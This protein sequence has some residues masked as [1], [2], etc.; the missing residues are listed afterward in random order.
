MIDMLC[1][2]I[3]TLWH[4]IQIGFLLSL[5]ATLVFLVLYFLYRA[6]VEMANDKAKEK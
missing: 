1:K 2:A 5:A 3:E 6:E 4:W